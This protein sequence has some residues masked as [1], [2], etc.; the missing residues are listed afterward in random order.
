MVEAIA[1]RLSGVSA[2]EAQ[3]RILRLVPIMGV[4]HQTPEYE[5][6]RPET[7]RSV[8]VSEISES[9]SVP[10][11][12]VVNSLAVPVLLIDG[13]EL[14]GAKQNRILNADVLVPAHSKVHIPVSCVE[15]GRWHH[16]SRTFSPGRSAGA[17]IRARKLDR[18]RRSLE[19]VGR[20]DAGQAE[21]WEEVERLLDAAE[22]D[23]PTRAMRDAY[24]KRA[25]ELESFRRNLALP[26]QA[27]GFAVFHGPRLKGLEIFDRH[28]TLAY[29]W[30]S[31][32]D[33]YTMWFMDAPVEP[34]QGD[35]P[36]A[37]EIRR[38]LDRVSAGD[39]RAF[40]PP[41]TGTDW[42]LS[43]EEYA[44]SALVWNNEVVLHLQVFPK[45]TWEEEYSRRR[46]PRTGDRR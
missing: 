11:L 44:A 8:T 45:R 20:Y 14:I 5:L 26:E 33:S 21:V 23:S 22:A 13:Q 12:K 42:R 40:D 46:A 30:P 29:I 3:G 36:D 10:L 41:G 18:V 7:L 38:V 37:V 28:S 43:D 19:A 16:I 25:A 9:G 6:L 35:S 2:H 1:R 32:V 24:E 17:L 34:A 31:L 27:V 15:S 39:W 4:S